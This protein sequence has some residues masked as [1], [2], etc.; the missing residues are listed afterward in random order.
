MAVAKSRWE[1][2]LHIDST[3]TSQ[4]LYFD[5]TSPSLGFHLLLTSDTACTAADMMELVDDV[6]EEMMELVDAPTTTIL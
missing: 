2:L 3:T 4:Q 1:L 6:V 5:L